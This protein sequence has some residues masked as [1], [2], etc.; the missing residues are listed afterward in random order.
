MALTKK[1]IINEI[2]INLKHKTVSVEKTTVIT[3]ENDIEIVKQ[4]SLHGFDPV[5]IDRL[6][7][8][9]GLDDTNIHINYIDS[10][11]T[12]EVIDAYNAKIAENY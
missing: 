11:W 9:T 12:Q 4:T 5:D 1:D 8:F 7:N 3:D 2:T 10:L 6:K